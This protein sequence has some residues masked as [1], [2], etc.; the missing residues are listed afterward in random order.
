MFPLTKA[1]TCYNCTNVRLRKLSRVEGTKTR[2]SN[3]G[4]LVLDIIDRSNVRKKCQV[5]I[6]RSFSSTVQ[7]LLAIRYTLMF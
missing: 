7:N 1:S 4:K 3:V 5:D 6:V 2:D